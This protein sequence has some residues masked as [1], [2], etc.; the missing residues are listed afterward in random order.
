MKNNFSY[1]DDHTR[2]AHTPSEQNAG[3]V[4]QGFNLIHFFLFFTTTSSRLC[5]W[6]YFS[7]TFATSS[8]APSS[9]TIKS[10]GIR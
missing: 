5:V 3:T 7:K 10:N 6:P 9:H 2:N 1:S 4:L 8:K